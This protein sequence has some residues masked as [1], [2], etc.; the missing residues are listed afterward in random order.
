M[1]HMNTLAA[2]TVLACATLFG[3]A[4]VSA[5]TPPALS[6]IVGM[7]G[8]S[9]ESVMEDRGYKFQFKKSASQMWWSRD[10]QKCV[11]VLID[12][13]RVASI[14]NATQNDCGKSG[15]SSNSG[16]DALGALAVVGLAAALAHHHGNDNRNN[17]T[18]HNSEYERGYN[19]AM[20]GGNY[21]QNDSAGYHSGYMAGETERNNRRHANSVLVRGAPAAAQNACK[22]RGDEFW[23]VASGSTVPVSVYDYGQGNYEI[24]VA[25]GYRRANCSVNA[26][27]DVSDFLQK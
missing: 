10:N 27:G 20:Y 11:S 25:S 12:D 7:R 17:N 15:G 8:S 16:S 4:E 18:A 9:F 6:D 24:T 2:G 19:D 1:N 21:A 14:Q 3:A 22:M 26:S 13:G 5:K 23:G